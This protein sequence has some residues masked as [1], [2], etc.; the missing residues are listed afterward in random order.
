MNLNDVIAQLYAA[1]VDCGVES[2]R[3]AGVVGW[4][5]DGHNRRVERHFR[6]DELDAVGEWLW[7]EALRQQEG[8]TGGTRSLLEELVGSRRK[9]PKRVTHSDRNE[10][11]R[12][13]GQ[14]DGTNH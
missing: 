1:A 11:K 3:G 6:I 2:Y 5:V 7:H 12:D 4:V 9:D 13:P 10:R 8:D 14:V